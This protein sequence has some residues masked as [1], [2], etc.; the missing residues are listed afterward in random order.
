MPVT[1]DNAA[2]FLLKID[3]K[4]VG[5]RRTARADEVVRR[6][7][8]TYVVLVN[9]MRAGNPRE[10]RFTAEAPRKGGIRRSGLDG[11]RRCL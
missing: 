8:R 5:F 3:A 6:N 2:P 4:E 10:V 7:A 9:Q 1:L 11:Y